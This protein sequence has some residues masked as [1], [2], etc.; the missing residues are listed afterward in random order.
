MNIFTLPTLHLLETNPFEQVLAS[1][2]A[3]A[4]FRV[5]LQDPPIFWNIDPLETCVADALLETG[6]PAEAA[7]EYRRILKANHYPLARYRLG[8]ALDRMGSKQEAAKEFE[9][10][11][12]AWKDADADVR[13]AIDA[14]Q[15]L[16]VLSH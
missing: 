6:H 4:H 7:A 2:K 1:P 3:L 12:E 14:R 15:R 13:E 8:L 16:A 10:F 9:R 5:V 11:L